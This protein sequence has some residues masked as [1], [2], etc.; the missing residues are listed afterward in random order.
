MMEMTLTLTYFGG[1]EVGH[2]DLGGCQT[3][4]P[5]PKVVVTLTACTKH[6]AGCLVTRAPS[7]PLLRCHVLLCLG[8]KWKAMSNTEKQPFYEEQSR[9]S[10]LHMEK[11]PDYRYRYTRRSLYLSRLGA[12]Q[13]SDSHPALTPHFPAGFNMGEVG[14]H[15]CKLWWC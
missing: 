4:S 13:S 11:H 1:V 10:K 9:L 8:A 12:G 7:S 5:F 6:G 15:T 14:V 2:S 3:R